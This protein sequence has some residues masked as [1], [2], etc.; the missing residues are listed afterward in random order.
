MRERD[1]GDT[2]EF[3]DPCDCVVV[4]V[5]DRIP[6]DRAALS[7]DEERTLAD[8]EGRC[9]GKPPQPG[10]FLPNVH[11]ATLLPEQ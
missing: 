6:H 4:D 10:H 9:R 7:G 11:A 1:G 3:G 5:G 2:A 8:T